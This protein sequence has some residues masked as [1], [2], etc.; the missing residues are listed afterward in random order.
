MDKQKKRK[1]NKKMMNVVFLDTV[2]LEC[3][4]KFIHSKHFFLDFVL[5]CRKT[6]NHLCDT[7]NRIK[8]RYLPQLLKLKT[9]N[10][11]EVFGK[12]CV[13]NIMDPNISLRVLE[14]LQAACNINDRNISVANESNYAIE[15]QKL[16]QTSEPSLLLFFGEVPFNSGRNM[17]WYYSRSEM[18]KPPRKIKQDFLPRFFY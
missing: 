16:A 18:Y 9:L 8:R 2:V 13:L 4:S 7:H 14:I 17:N 5:V 1:Q 3:I 15:M 11:L 12:D 6:K 10:P